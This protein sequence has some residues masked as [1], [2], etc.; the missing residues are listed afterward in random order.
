M[1][2]A[3]LFFCSLRLAAPLALASSSLPRLGCVW[4]VSGAAQLRAPNPAHTRAH[5]CSR[6]SPFLVLDLSQ[7]PSFVVSLYTSTTHPTMA[8]SA[9]EQDIQMLLAAQCHLGT[10]VR[11][12]RRKRRGAGAAETGRERSADRSRL[13][14]SALPFR[15][16][17]APLS[18]PSTEPP[19]L[20]GA[21]RIQAP[22]G[23]HPRH[24]RGGDVAE[25]A[26]GRARHRRGREPA[27]EEKKE[28]GGERGG[29]ARTG[30]GLT[31]S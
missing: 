21:V 25:D 5:Q 27:G 8:L 4:S 24:Q 9:K 16:T 13:R 12:E 23:R 2:A 22:R 30:L 31:P 3:V 6:L 20:H 10:K 18:L 19:P 14:S 1:R 15:L 29:R 26:A 17:L 11:E 7:P 28:R